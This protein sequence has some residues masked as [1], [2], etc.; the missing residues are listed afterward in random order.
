M[1][2]EKT[3]FLFYFYSVFVR[4]RAI[5]SAFPQVIVFEQYCFQSANNRR[6]LTGLSHNK[7]NNKANWITECKHEQ[8]LIMTYLFLQKHLD[9]F[10]S[11]SCMFTC[12][13]LRIF[14]RLK[15][16]KP[17]LLWVLK[18]VFCLQFLIGTIPRTRIILL[19]PAH[20]IKLLSCCRRNCRVPIKM[21]WWMWSNVY[22]L[23]SKIVETYKH[24]NKRHFMIFLVNFY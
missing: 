11:F 19:V 1:V 3:F 20:A 10:F 21:E 24:P 9:S 2:P 22:L 6:D 16:T 18:H 12:N 5:Y 14:K 4:S 7:K 13:I 23:F 17:N 8:C 15:I